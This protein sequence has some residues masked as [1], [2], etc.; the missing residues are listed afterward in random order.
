MNGRPFFYYTYG[1]AVAEVVIDTLTGENRCLRV[2]IAQD[3][4]K[5]LNPIIGLG[6]YE[7]TF[8][9]GMGWLTCEEVWWDGSGRLRTVGPPTYKI[10][11]S[12]DVP[13]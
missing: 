8:L 10:P 5:P 9:Q 2:D 6:Q 7:G 3:C 1:P 13:P 4:G 12:R 11:G